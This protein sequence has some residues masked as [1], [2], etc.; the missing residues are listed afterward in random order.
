MKLTDYYLMRHLSTSKSKYRLDCVYSTGGYEPF[1]TSATR[2]RDRRFKFYLSTTPDTF[3]ADAQRKS[4]MAITDGNSISSVYFPDLDNPLLGY[5]DVAGTNDALLF[6]FND[7]FTEVEM[8]VA[9][10]LKKHQR[11]L[12][13]L[14]TDGEL[15]DEME[16]LIKLAKPTN[17]YDEEDNCRF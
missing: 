6:L 12:F 14:L 15:A 3:S 9:R 11:G 1:E 10:G 8:F 5:G 7:D 16:Q 2:S 17:A 13:T 4:D